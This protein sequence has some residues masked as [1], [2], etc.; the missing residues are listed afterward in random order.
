MAALAISVSCLGLLGM[1]IYTTENRRK[2]VA[3]RKTLGAN[4]WRL[5]Y[6]LSGLFFRMWIIAL[7]IGIPLSYLF[8]DN[9]IMS[10]YNKFS[11]GVGFSEVAISSLFTL[12]LGL[13]SIMI[14]S[15]R[16]MNTNPAQNLRNE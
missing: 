3:I 15:N 7:F 13:L 11:S 4:K 10:V 14:Q 9:I 1:V 8:Y 2:E 5:L 16:V 6:T 12:A